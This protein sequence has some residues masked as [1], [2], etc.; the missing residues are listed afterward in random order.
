L[1]WILRKA[2]SA[3]AQECV[4]SKHA[5]FSEA[6]ESDLRI[7][8]AFMVIMIPRGPAF[9]SLIRFPQK[10]RLPHSRSGLRFILRIAVLASLVC[11]SHGYVLEGTHWPNPTNLTFHVQLGTLTR[12]LQDGSAS[13]SAAVAPV[14]TTW[15][16]SLGGMKL[17]TVATSTA[18]SSGDG[19]NSVFF[20]P[21]IFGQ[22]FGANTLA[23][24][25][26]RTM[27]N[28]MVEADVIFNSAKAF[29]SYRGPLQ[30]G[31]NGYAIPDIRRVLLHELGHGIGLDHPD[32]HGQ[33]VTAVMNS[34]ISN[35]ETLSTDDKN[36]GQSLYGAPSNPAPI[37]SASRLVNISTRMR[38]GT[39]DDVLIG[40]FIISGT[41]SKKII[42]RALGPSLAA[43]GIAG[44]LSNPTMELHNSSG[45]LIASNDDWQQSSQAAQ[46]A[47]SGIPPTNPMESAIIAT[48]AP[49]SYTAIVRGV[50]NMTGIAMI[51]GYE[52]GAGTAKLVN[53]STR[54]RV[55]TG[56]GVLIGGFI[57]QGSAS[58]KI[59]IRAAGPS[60]GVGPG[61][62]SH[63]LANPFL[64]LRNS[65][66][67][68]VAS[69]DNW[70][71]SPSAAQ[72]TATGIPPARA[73]ESAI[74]AT[75]TP[76]NYTAIV[77]GVNN[78][79]GVALVELYDLD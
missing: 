76:G 12:Q 11:T 42:L 4:V 27:N 1:D 21:T 63:A 18:V 78:T 51:E 71:S 20:A 60:L 72:I 66:G 68:L 29:D 48:L 15:N 50:N 41:Q 47:S 35:Q 32:T 62:V 57:V 17:N 30:F 28:V 75:L 44:A 2:R 23:V 6:N 61:A 52:L 73:E 33:H 39:G 79:T 26:W 16:G 65:A 77:R 64:E 56:D 3:Y 59:L 7:N 9:L 13:W 45:G 14:F 25:Y 74:L 70:G 67:S 5:K 55:A 34:V 53:I 49:G 54:G 40:G 36:G 69:N 24:T 22:S 38:V 43:S 37:T 8:L 31:S 46:I 58:K 19:V 10:I